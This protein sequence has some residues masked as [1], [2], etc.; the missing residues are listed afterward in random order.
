MSPVMT[1]GCLCGGVRYEYSGEVGRAAYCHC[2]DCRKCTG[3]AFNISVRIQ[4]DRFRIVSGV[5]SGFTK[6]ADSGNE[7]TRHFCPACG[8]PIYTSSPRH[9][10]ALYVKAGSLDDPALVRPHH[11]SWMRSKVQWAAID[12]D[13]PG[14]PEGR[15]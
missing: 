4:A 3:S 7:L 2:S 12:P 8:S 14:Y 13:L 10:D 9:P 15:S 6:T 11:Q 5:P 1:G